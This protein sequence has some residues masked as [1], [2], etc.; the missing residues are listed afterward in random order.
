MNPAE[1]S[2]STIQSP[3]RISVLSRLMRFRSS[4]LFDALDQITPSPVSA[5]SLQYAV[6]FG[7]SFKATSELVNW[8]F[9]RVAMDGN[10]AR[11]MAFSY[12]Q[13]TAIASDTFP[14]ESSRSSVSE[15]CHRRV[16]FS[17]CSWTK[18]SRRRYTS[19]GSLGRPMNWE[20]HEMIFVVSV[21]E[22]EGALV[23]VLVWTKGSFSE[24]FLKG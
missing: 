13:N 23:L 2:N 12:L 14:L 18:N 6:G 24:T 4:P 9:C 20:C 16:L 11:E 22:S 1:S 3:R 15:I 8:V 19:S 7:F 21:D 17:R 5:F 10:R